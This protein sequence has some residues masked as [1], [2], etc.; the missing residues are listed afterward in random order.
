M[1]DE[2]FKQT[3]LAHA[4]ESKEFHAKVSTALFGDEDSEI[5][6]V[7]KRVKNLETYKDADEKFKQKVAGGLFVIS[8]AGVPLWEWIKHKFLGL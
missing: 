1:S 5:I 7:A 2:E 3:M 4:K 6:G 8:I